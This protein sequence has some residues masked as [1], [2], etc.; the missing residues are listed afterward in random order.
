MA[1]PFIAG[2]HHRRRYRCSDGR[3]TSSPSP[4]Q[5]TG[6]VELARRAAASSATARV[7]DFSRPCCAVASCWDHHIPGNDRRRELDLLNGVCCL[8]AHLK[9]DSPTSRVVGRQRRGGVVVG[10]VGSSSMASGISAASIRQ[11]FEAAFKPSSRATKSLDTSRFAI[12]PQQSDSELVLA[13][14]HT[15][16]DHVVSFLQHEIGYSLL[17]DARSLSG[18]G[19]GLRAHPGL[20][21]V[22]SRGNSSVKSPKE[23]PKVA[24]EEAREVIRLSLNVAKSAHY[25]DDLVLVFRFASMLGAF[26][27]TAMPTAQQEDFYKTVLRGVRLMHLCDFNYS[28]I[29]LTLSYASV[30]FRG[31]L[32]TVGDRMTVPEAAHV[33]VLTIYLAHSFVLD[34]NCPLKHWQKHIFKN[35]CTLK[36]L[37]AA[38]FRMFRLKDFG[39]RISREEEKLALSSLLRSANDLD[40]VLTFQKDTGQ[41][42]ESC[43]NGRVVNGEGF[44]VSKKQVCLVGH[45]SSASSAAN[46]HQDGPV[47]AKV[48]SGHRRRKPS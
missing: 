36:V 9:A 34:E 27:P 45:P 37:D 40:V 22:K 35:Y 38:L 7:P 24:D 10:L 16:L 46:G 41:Y 19:V 20:E 4:R 17:A 31:V 39:L 6:N 18:G 47:S 13:E 30:Y 1:I 42:L 23:E 2:R 12:L 28:D 8:G 48:G 14:V 43:V 29:V 33:C 21:P 26:S 25:P 15:K 11:L 5:R 3:T 32:E 44:P